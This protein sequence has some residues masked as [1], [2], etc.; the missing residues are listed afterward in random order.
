MNSFKTDLFDPLMGLLQVLPLG[1]RVGL[2]VIAIKGY[3]T[4]PRFPVLDPHYQIQFSVKPRIPPF[5]EGDLT[6][7]QKMQSSY[8]KP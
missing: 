6:P 7:P 8:C 1:V 4:L 3:S 5:A 2:R